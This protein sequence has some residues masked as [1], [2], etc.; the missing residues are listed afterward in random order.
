MVLLV[1]V[2][3]PK[4]SNTAES[5]IAISNIALVIDHPIIHPKDVGSGLKS[6]VNF[7]S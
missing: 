4:P 5:N 2:I 7:G 1:S 3:A 6:T